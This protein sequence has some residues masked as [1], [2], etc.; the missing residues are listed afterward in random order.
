MKKSG[1]LAAAMM[2]A[3]VIGGCQTAEEKPV[4]NFSTF[5]SAAFTP[6]AVEYEDT[7][8]FNSYYDELY[9]YRDGALTLL[10]TGFNAKSMTELNGFL[11]YYCLDDNWEWDGVYKRQ[12]SE[13]GM[14]IGEPEK[15]YDLSGLPMERRPIAVWVIENDL[16][17]LGSEGLTR[18]HLTD[19]SETFWEFQWGGGSLL[20]C[21]HKLYLNTPLEFPNPNKLFTIDLDNGQI[22]IIS[23]EPD[24]A[25]GVR[26]GKPVIR[27]SGSSDPPPIP[28]TDGYAYYKDQN[29]VYIKKGNEYIYACTIPI[30]GSLLDPQFLTVGDNLLMRSFYP[31]DPSEIDHNIPGNDMTDTNI[32]QYLLTPDGELTLLLADDVRFPLA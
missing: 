29:G 12:L 24:F 20:V 15:V 13:D 21:D 28:F 5:N 11:Y 17:L 18:V 9:S 6:Y 26:D 10:E 1:L 19:G 16:Y 14:S 32:Y 23:E 25:A 7:L 4:Y 31:A 8:Y 27:Y 2:A 3:V 30:Q 22:E